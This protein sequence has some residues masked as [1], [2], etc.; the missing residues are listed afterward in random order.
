MAH[1]ILSWISLTDQSM[2]SYEWNLST[3]QKCTDKNPGG[4]KDFQFE[5]VKLRDGRSLRG[6]VLVGWEVQPGRLEYR[7]ETGQ[8]NKEL[9]VGK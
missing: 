9:V 4:D 1:Y 5:F 2:E 8:N 3:P 6:C 7:V